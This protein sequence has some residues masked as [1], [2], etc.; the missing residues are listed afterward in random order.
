[1]EPHFY[2]RHER[3]HAAWGAGEA[4]Q[5]R[6]ESGGQAPWTGIRRGA[7]RKT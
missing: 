5:E 4:I 2:L 6:Q 3:N 1:M 7:Q